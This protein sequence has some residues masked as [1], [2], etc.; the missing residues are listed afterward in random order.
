MEKEKMEKI[1]KI[2]L[3][4]S[5]GALV[6]ACI[7]LVLAVF[8]VK[9][10]VGVPLRILLCISTLSVACGLALS[11]LVIFEKNKILGIIGLGLL[12]LSTLLALIC[13]C[14]SLLVTLSVYNRITGIVAVLSVIYTLALVVYSRLGKHILGL[15]IVTYFAMAVLTGFVVLIIAGVPVFE[16][17][18]MTE[19]FII[20][21]IVS[22]GTFLSCYFIGAKLKDTSAAMTKMGIKMVQVE[23]S[24]WDNLNRQLDVLKNENE[25]L[26][27]ENEILK[28][29][30]R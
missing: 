4:L 5:I 21:C 20:T 9:I 27:K 28:G 11:D 26:K 14:T 15:Q 1:R 12:A 16:Q 29:Q 10:F 6:V 30:G 8:R 24:E 18:G 22:A 13:F 7:M 19:T 23:Q 3:A 25:A 17:P 2:L